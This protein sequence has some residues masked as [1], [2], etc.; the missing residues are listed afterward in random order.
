[1]K[2]MPKGIEV[3]MEFAGAQLQLAFVADAI[4]IKGA[5]VLEKVDTAAHV[6]LA[7]QGHADFRAGPQQRSVNADS[8][9]AG[10]ASARPGLA[11]PLPFPGAVRIQRRAGSRLRVRARILRDR[12][13]VVIGCGR[14]TVIRKRDRGRTKQCRGKIPIEFSHPEFPHAK[15]PSLP[16]YNFTRLLLR[17]SL[18]M[19]GRLRLR[20]IS[21][22]RSVDEKE[23]RVQTDSRAM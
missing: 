1:M 4:M 21:P 5:V 10:L 2:A 17:A 9:K 8:H 18:P 12:R 11:R 16:N 14:C 19:P 7:S 6:Q 15:S 22:R 23:D 3:Q 13:R 20:A